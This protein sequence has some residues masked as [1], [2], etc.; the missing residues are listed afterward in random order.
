MVP[1]P[2]NVGSVVYNTATR[3]YDVSA[4]F[5]LDEILQETPNIFEG[6]PFLED[7]G[8]LAELSKKMFTVTA[9][10]VDGKSRFIK[11]DFPD[12]LAE[13]ISKG[14]KFPVQVSG[15]VVLAYN[16]DKWELYYGYITLKRDSTLKSYSTKKISIP[17][18]DISVKGG[19]K[20]SALL[21][22]SL[23]INESDEVDYKYGGV[24]YAGLNLEGSISAGTDDFNVTGYTD[25]GISS[26]VH[27]TGYMSVRATVYAGIKAKFKYFSKTLFQTS[28]VDKTWDNGGTPILMSAARMLNALPGQSTEVMA[29]DYLQRGSEWPTGNTNAKLMA[30]VSLENPEAI[31]M[32]TNIYP[33]SEVQLVRHGDELWMVWTDDNPS[34]SSMNRTQMMY[35]VYKDGNWSDPAWVGT[36]KTAD[37][38]PSADS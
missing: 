7:N 14:M 25:A 26:Q 9:Y 3:S 35:S 13:M 17:V 2:E 27:T 8:N 21:G 20:L 22:A 12:E 37:F 31:I 29:R 10:N 24:V 4:T 23:V 19:L 5:T 11:Y 32:K 1:Q 30:S 6:I 36:D 15:K 28:L 16:G 33:D 18:V 38:I 34:R